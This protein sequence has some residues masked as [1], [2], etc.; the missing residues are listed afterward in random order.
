MELQL[1]DIP[2]FAVI[3]GSTYGVQYFEAIRNMPMK[4]GFS[5]LVNELKQEINVA[6]SVMRFD[7]E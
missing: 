1:S 6:K 3:S 5:G 4:T 7:L 2:S